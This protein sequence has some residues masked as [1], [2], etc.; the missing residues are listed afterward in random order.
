MLPALMAKFSMLG[1]LGFFFIFKVSLFEG[2]G[3]SFANSK[4]YDPKSKF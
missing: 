1:F 3:I 4:N 2:E